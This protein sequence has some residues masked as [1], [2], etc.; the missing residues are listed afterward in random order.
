MKTKILD[1]SKLKSVVRLTGS[2]AAE[3]L[4]ARR[5]DEEAS[6][7]RH[8]QFCQIK[9]DDDRTGVL[10]ATAR[11]VE[12][13]STFKSLDVRARA[14]N[15]GIT[16][17]DEFEGRAL[18]FY[19]SDQRVDRHGD[20][21]RQIWNLKDFQANPILL[22]GHMWELPPI[23]NSIAENVG[24]RKA[25]DY[26]GPALEIMTL[27]TDSWDLARDVGTLVLE[28]FLK[29]GSV[30]FFPGAIL[31]V[32]DKDER[33]EIGLGERGLIFGDDDEPNDLVEFTIASVPANPGAHAAHLCSLAAEEKI[34]PASIQLIRELARR[35]ITRGAG[36]LAE[37][38][39][40]DQTLRA[41]LASAFPN[42][43]IPDHRELDAPLMLDALEGAGGGKSKSKQKP[44]KR[45]VV[46]KSHVRRKGEDAGEIGV[47]RHIT[48]GV[49]LVAFDDEDSV[50][51]KV[52]DLE[53]VD[54][55]K[56][57]RSLAIKSGDFVTYEV[58]GVSQRGD[59]KEICEDVAMV[60]RRGGDDVDLVPI[61]KLTLV[62][63]SG[64]S[65]LSDRLD[66]IESD[67]TT[68]LTEISEQI[69]ALQV[70]A[71]GLHAD[72]G[73]PEDVPDDVIARLLD[74]SEE[75]LAK[76]RGSQTG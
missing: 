25:A 3:L 72:G 66:R 29:T 41:V 13:I 75:T 33:A 64:S 42:V 22:Y 14:E 56:R 32:K 39:E 62:E 52:D 67:L 21:V 31:D 45:A 55:P 46:K 10:K 40:R 54:A 30:G 2:K 35:E 38:R 69:A 26:D 59:V 58:D 65:D 16:W 60:E 5:K 70:G 43:S 71:S 48:D 44:K 34:G 73:D 63:R 49:A 28:G 24:H 9:Q 8:T 15:R 53:V 23:G 11:S 6:K 50:L 37:W 20:I 68:Q 12:Q 19:A 61:G 36:D 1:L 57:R 7:S 17:R 74:M 4:D 18:P 27:F 47:V 76:L 51:V